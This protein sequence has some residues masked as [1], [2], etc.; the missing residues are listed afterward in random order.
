MPQCVTDGLSLVQLRILHKVPHVCKGMK[1]DITHPLRILNDLAMARNISSNFDLLPYR[2]NFWFRVIDASI[3]WAAAET[4]TQLT[5]FLWYAPKKQCPIFKSINIEN[6]TPLPLIIFSLKPY[7]SSSNIQPSCR[8][9]GHNRKERSNDNCLP[10][11]K[12]PATVWKNVSLMDRLRLLVHAAL[13]RQ[14]EYRYVSYQIEIWAD[15]K[16]FAVLL[17]KQITHPV[18]T[19]TCGH[20]VFQFIRYRP[21]FKKGP[22]G[23]FPACFCIVRAIRIRIG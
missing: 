1:S 20:W 12:D 4:G 15:K 16:R 7:F 19:C 5:I 3:C 23:Y 21:P 8:Q 11:L 9:P 18:R 2:D 22:S 14:E 13:Y 10:G 6:T 17:H